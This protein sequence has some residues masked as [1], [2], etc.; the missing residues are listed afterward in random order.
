[1]S[2]L[3]NKKP[4]VAWV[5]RFQQLQ[6][7]SRP[8][9]QNLFADSC[10][11]SRSLH[12]KQMMADKYVHSATF[13]DDGSYFLSNDGKGH[14]LLWSIGQLLGCERKPNPTIML[15]EVEEYTWTSCLAISSDN[16][17]ILSNDSYSSVF[18]HDTQ[19]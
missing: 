15:N 17:K 10:L 6:E 14:V 11:K 5:Q 16:K 7:A 19:T 1:M 8:F 2:N 3:K 18:I 13:S 9:S 4:S 12:C